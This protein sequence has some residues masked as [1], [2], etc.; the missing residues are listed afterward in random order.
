MG[1]VTVTKNTRL[2]I[3]IGQAANR[4][5]AHIGWALIQRGRPKAAGYRIAGDPLALARQAALD[6]AG[7]P[8]TI[9]RYEND[10]AYAKAQGRKDGLSRAA[11]WAL[12]QSIADQLASEGFDIIICEIE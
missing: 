9:Y 12:V 2:G 10:D 6:Q 3:K 4:A 7:A 8:L 11:H 5:E 1:S